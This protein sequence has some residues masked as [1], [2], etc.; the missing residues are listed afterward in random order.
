VPKFESSTSPVIAKPRQKFCRPISVGGAE[1]I[2]LEEQ[3]SKKC[4]NGFNVDPVQPFPP[5]LGVC[6]IPIIIGMK[7]RP[8][9]NHFEK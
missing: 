9:I 2:P 1:A 5:L 3:G 4:S 8:K 7:Q 6:F